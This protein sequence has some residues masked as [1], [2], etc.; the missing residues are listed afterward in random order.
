[1]YDIENRSGKSR[2]IIHRYSFGRDPCDQILDYDDQILLF[3][4][5]NA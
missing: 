2:K 1:M 4:L 5:T 3:N